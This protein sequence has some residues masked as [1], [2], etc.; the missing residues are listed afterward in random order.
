MKAR[1]PASAGR[2]VFGDGV[3]ESAGVEVGGVLIRLWLFWIASPTEVGVCCFVRR[4]SPDPD[5][6]VLMLSPIHEPSCLFLIVPLA[7]RDGSAALMSQPDVLKVLVVDDSAFMRRAIANMLK[8]DPGIEVVGTARDGKDAVAKVAELRP[9]VVT[10]D[11]EMPEMDGL[12]ALRRI[13]ELPLTPIPAVLMCSS[14]TTSGSREAL[15]ALT[16]GAA[17][18]IA[19]DASNY[20]ANM[21][22]MRDELISKVKAIGRRVLRF[23]G[24][25]SATLGKSSPTS[26]AIAGR[27]SASAGGIAGSG[28]QQVFNT[29]PPVLDPAQFDVIV[30]GSSTGGPPALEKVLV[31]IAPQMPAPIII[32]QHMPPVFT[33]SMSGRLHDQCA[34]HVMHGEHGMPLY[35]GTATVIPGGQHGRVRMQRGGKLFLDVGP[36]PT[37]AIYKPS[38][39]ELFS[40]AAATCGARTLGIMLTGMGEDGKT[41][42]AAIKKAGGIIVAQDEATSVVWGMPRAVAIDGTAVAV[43][44]IDRIAMLLNTLSGKRPSGNAGQIA[45]NAA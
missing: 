37:S 27:T 10:L 15:K 21:D 34:I 32:A 26:P 45:G 35:P 28:E 3:R 6:A 5:S 12:E 22:A 17:D 25:R 9:H 30:I 36:E 2:V 29:T 1:W 4:G 20:S 38:V 8:E 44:P 19:K 40:S 23:G 11:I 24:C 41:G 18:V 43:L 33:Q 16:L 39:N 13:R 31:T 42:A 14:L 7:G